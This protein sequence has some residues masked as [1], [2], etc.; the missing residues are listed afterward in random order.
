MLTFHPVT[1]DR[2]LDRSNPLYVGH[3]FRLKGMWWSKR[4]QRQGLIISVAL[5]WYRLV[6]RY[7]GGEGFVERDTLI[8]NLT[9]QVKDSRRILDYFFEV[10]RMGFNMGGD[11]KAPTTVTP[12]R[13][14]KKIK[15]AIAALLG[16]IRFDPGPPPKGNH[17]LSDVYVQAENS[18]RIIAELHRTKREDLIPPVQW[19]LQQASPITFYFEPSGALQARDKSVWPIRTIETWPGWLRT[20]LFGTVVDIENAYVQFL[21]HQLEQKYATNPNRMELKYPDLLR[22]DR[23]KQAFR[24]ELCADVLKLPVNKDNIDKV[25]KLIMSIANGSNATPALMTNG[26]GRSEA[27]RIVHEMCPDML[28]TDLAKVGARL[29]KITKQFVAARRD[30]CIHILGEKPT[31]AN[32]KKIFQLYFDWERMARYE[33]WNATGR[34]GLH[35]HDGIDGV[36]TDMSEEELAQLVAEKTKIRVSVTKAINL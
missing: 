12:R 4:K 19:I 23:E 2:D 30:L 10:K 14:P 22:A 31:R 17:T 36:K 11:N 9:R 6:T 7:P 26:S 15:R 33:I 34:T 16:E 32:Q 21:I 28:P 3:F 13:L 24:E 27:V 1:V 5:A 20:S 8:T 18:T 35:L 29:S 25:K